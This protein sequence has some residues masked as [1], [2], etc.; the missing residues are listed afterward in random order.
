MIDPDLGEVD[1]G[2]EECI[3]MFFLTDVNLITVTT[4]PKVR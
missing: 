1:I 3:D 4:I 2:T